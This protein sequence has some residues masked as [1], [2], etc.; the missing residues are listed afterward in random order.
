M[1]HRH[2]L[3]K[4]LLVM[5]QMKKE[6]CT[7]NDVTVGLLNWLVDL[8]QMKKLWNSVNDDS[9]IVSRDA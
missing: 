9:F 5:N 4:T 2:D 1:C 8:G 7:P 6:G 3:E